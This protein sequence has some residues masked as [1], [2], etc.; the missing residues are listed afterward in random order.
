MNYGIGKIGKPKTKSRSA[1][2]TFT[3]IAKV[4]D[5]FSDSQRDCPCPKVKRFR[6]VVFK[7]TGD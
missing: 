2:A 3:F 1:T 4:T 6:W 5:I 7:M